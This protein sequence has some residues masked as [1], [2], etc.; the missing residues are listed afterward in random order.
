M[1]EKNFDY[2]KYRDKLAAEVKKEL[3]REKRREILKSAQETVDYHK[4]KSLH[5][6]EREKLLQER[7]LKLPILKYAR[8]IKETVASNQTIIIVGETG[9]GKTTQIPLLLR[10]IMSP[11][12]RV[13]ITQPRRVA[14]RSVARYVAENVGCRIGEEVGYQVR[15]EDHTTEGTRIN[16]MTDGIL[17]R[18]IQEDPLLQDY[19]AVMVDEAHERS[20]NIDFTLGLLKRL[21]RKRAEAGLP[22][23]KIIVT[24]ATLEKEKFARYFGDSPMVEVPGRLYPVEIHYEKERVYDYTKAAAEKVRM[25]VEQNKE[26]DILI[27]MPGQEE[28]DKTI[29][30]IEALRL[31]G[32]TVLPL[33]GQMSPEEQDRIFEKMS[34]RKVIVATNIAETSVTVPGIHHVIDSGLIKQIEFDPSTGI[35]TLAPR[36]HA[37]SGCIQRAGRAGRLAPGECWRLYPESDFNNRPEFQTPEIQRSNLA[38]VVLMMKKIGIE[39]VKSFEFIDPPEIKTLEQAIDTLKTLGALDENERI[40]EIG[41][42]MAEF[43]LEPHIARMVIEAEKHRCVETICTIASFLGGRSVFVRPKGKESEADA[44]HRRFKVPESDFLTLLKVWQEYEANDYRDGWAR[45][46]F[47]HTKMLAEVRQVRY[48]LFRVLRRNGIRASE[49]QDPEAIGKSIAAGLIENLMEYYSRHSYRRVKDGESGFFI[50]PS[51]VTFGRNPK[52]FVPAEIVRT[53]KTYARI[54]QEVKP[55]WIREIAPQLTREEVREAYYDPA[56][57]RVLRK[58]DIY[59]KGNYN[60][61]MEEE[62]LVTGEEAVKIFAEALSRGKIDLLF[63][64]HNKQVMETINDLWLRNEGKFMERPFSLENLKTFYIKQ[65]GNIS[66][67]KELEKALQEGKINLELNLDEL[68]PPERREEILRG[69]PDSI[70]ILGIKRQIRYRYDD[71]DKKFTAVV[72]IP[73]SDV[74]KL[75]EMPTLPSGRSITFEIVSQE[76]ETYTQ[77]SGTNIQELKQKSRQ[78]LIKKQWDEWQSSGKAPQEKR[79]ENFDPLETLPNLP[80]PVQ[81]GFDPETGEPIFAFPAI[82]VE[83]SYYSGNKYSI[84][85]FPS[86]EEAEIAQVKALEVIEQTKIEQ[87]KKEERERLLAPARELLQRLKNNFSAIGEDYMDYG[88]FYADKIDLYDKLLEAGRK[89]ESDPKEAMEILQEI[90]KRLTQAFNY[91]EQIRVA[92]EKAEAAIA[93]HYSSCPLCGKPL[94]NDKCTNSEHD[95]ERIDFASDE[96]GNET[97]PVILSQIITDQGKIVAQLRVSH[98]E[99]RGRNRRYRG[100]VYLVRGPG[101]ENG[102]WGGLFESLKFEDFG[103]ILTPEQAKSKKAKMEAMR[104]EKARAEA[105]ARYQEELEYA[106]QQV[107]QGYWR[108]GKFTKGI[109]PKTGDEQWELTLKG[110]GLVVKYI[111]DRWSRQPT[112]EDFVYFYSEEKTIVDTRGFRLILVRLENPFPEDKPEEPEASLSSQAKSSSQPSK[113]S[114]EELKRKWGAR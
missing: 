70:D 10:E 107:E 109:H 27:F 75:T 32:L 52:F 56:A 97:G 69:N 76:G 92:K 108:M 63:V 73:A 59:L 55:E 39:D 111:V 88:L 89:I 93:E 86:R 51:S 22:P 50:H 35:E 60:A 95:P 48:Q 61:F 21:Q 4:A 65:L 103:K 104:R 28:I 110:R 78:F 33:Y 98:G 84:K 18:K 6:K 19:S 11:E 23:I 14:A 16:F 83:S 44:A 13:A 46:N 47:L 113:T 15:F 101:I 112:S 43:P 45:D 105:L 12:D 57:D 99:G 36:P 53:N 67:S 91:K 2:K 90:D 77:F 106:K 82:T 102:W 40:T 38:H 30:E 5:Q 31:S 85:Y 66:S 74:L 17:L 3:D 100:E 26:G 24:S 62:K 34:G 72:Q 7:E 64:R 58:V 114:L 1:V 29:K 8:E 49:S 87:R 54:I 20:L 68:I 42:T 9:S 81:F 79:L 41:E 71:W 94:E 96:N 25:I 37:K 80:E